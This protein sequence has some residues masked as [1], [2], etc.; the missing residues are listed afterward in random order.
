[1]KKILSSFLPLILFIAVA[2]AF[3]SAFLPVSD[4]VLVFSVIIGVLPLVMD[5]FRSLRQ[6]RIDLGAPVVITILLLLFL[7]K[8]ESAA[9][10]VLLILAGRL[11]KEYIL[12]RVRESVASISKALPDV[13]Y[14][15]HGNEIKE[16]HISAIIK[17]DTVIVKGGGRVPV[18]GIL[19]SEFASLD[20]SVISGESKPVA[21]QKGARLVAASINLSDYLELQAADISAN[22]TLAQMQKLVEEAQKRN[23]PLSRFTTQ[24]AEV[25]SIVALLSVIVIYLLTKNVEKSLALWITLVPVIF[26]IIVP[27]ATTIGISLL[28]KTGVLVK[29]AEALENLTKINVL[30][31][32]KTG[33]LTLGKPEISKIVTLEGLSEDILVQTAGSVERFSEHSLGEPIVRE[34]QRR[35]LSWLD[36]M[37]VQVQKGRGISAMVSGN[38]VLIGNKEFIQEEGIPIS[39]KLETEARKIEESGATSIWIAMQDKLAGL[40]FLADQLRAETKP[41]LDVLRQLGY[42]LV[43]LTGDHLEVAA[44]IGEQA[45]VTQI[46][47]GLLPQDKIDAIKKIKAAGKYVLMVGDGIND[48]PA[49]AEANV[50][51]AMGLRGVGITLESAQVVLIHDSLRV[52]P[53]VF[54][55]AKR[56]FRIIR[57]DLILATSIHGIA[58]VLVLFGTI[59][60]L[61]STVL[62]QISSALVLLNTLRLLRPLRG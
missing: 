10:F 41:T 46:K 40:I 11:F 18:D 2:I 6:K 47:A 16:V 20:E 59:G 36:V 39:S 33:T 26:A 7:R 34:V 12:W 4:Y 30:C 62:H 17:G 27:V 15:R 49:L 14:V 3:H 37:D 29:T 60:I 48:A 43:M 22:S 57:F 42:S 23:A 55:V 54:S 61:G 56:T 24:Y 52:L 58:A 45:G 44:K 21:K 50:G 5:I 25:T 1:M 51:V 53:Q 31:F 8:F 9:I 35:K 38:R 28:T 13:S 19:L 32:D